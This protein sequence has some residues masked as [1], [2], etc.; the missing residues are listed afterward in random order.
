MVLYYACACGTSAMCVASAMACM[1]WRAHAGNCLEV[2]RPGPVVA[3]D[4]EM[5][6]KTGVMTVSLQEFRLLPF[7]GVTPQVNSSNIA[8][9]THI[10]VHLDDAAAEP[11]GPP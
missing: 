7:H 8:M 5:C 4:L 11:R 1:K 2:I 10:L 3:D 6:I 9:G